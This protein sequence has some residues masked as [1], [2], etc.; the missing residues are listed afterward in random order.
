[1]NQNN[2]LDMY[3]KYISGSIERIILCTKG[4][5]TDEINWHPKG[6]TN[7]I[8]VLATHMIGNLE[9]NIL[10]II[11]GMNVKRNRE[12]EFATKGISYEQI[13]DNW[14]ELKRKIVNHQQQF[15]VAKM[16]TE[17]E[18]PRLGKISIR[19]LLLVIARHAAEHVGHAELTRDLLFLEYGKQPPIREY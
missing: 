1:M 4:L 10:G 16:E 15:P 11:Y 12:A 2:E 7:S 13:R 5:S 17:I 6:K 19:E 14:T 9:F 18:H 8:F 3:W